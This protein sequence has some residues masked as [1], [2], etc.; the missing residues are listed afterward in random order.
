MFRDDI[1]NNFT[2][3]DGLISPHPCKNTD[4]NA[5]NN[6]LAYLGEYH[7][8]LNLLKQ[9]NFKDSIK[10]TKIVYSCEAAPGCFNR[11]PHNKVDYESI[12]DYLGLCCA[13][14]FNNSSIVGSDILEYGLHNYGSYNNI[15]PGHFQWT[16]M[17]WRDPTLLAMM[18]WASNRKVW[19]PL[20]LIV[21]LYIS[22][23]C[24]F[25]NQTDGT[26]I[27]RLSW[28]LIQ[29]AKR[30]SWMCRIA[31]KLWYRR[32]KNVWGSM[33]QVA[34]VYYKGLPGQDHPFVDAMKQLGE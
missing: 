14:Y 20:N 23:V 32:L 8:L 19:F 11:S 7:T 28:L 33:E 34:R 27:W 5:S 31:S 15:N 18:L 10:F 24:M 12:D 1:E 21:A 9:S 30:E 2:D 26:D 4:I 16:T 17:L 3:S 13:I 22:I 25:A 6:G 29:V